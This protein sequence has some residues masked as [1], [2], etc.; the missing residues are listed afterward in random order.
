MI[1]KKN[2]FFNPDDYDHEVLYFTEELH[3]IETNQHLGFRR[4]EGLPT[5]P[6]GSPGRLKFLLTEPVTLQR[7]HK[8]VTIKA[9]TKRPIYVEGMILSVGGKSKFKG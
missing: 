8:Q 5:R 4:L 1:I 7:G 3:N 6:I 2:E 9:S